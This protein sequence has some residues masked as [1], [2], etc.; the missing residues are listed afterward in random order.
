M[1]KISQLT[2]ISNVSDDDLFVVSQQGT[3][4]NTRADL[5]KSF[6]NG[7]LSGDLSVGTPNPNQYATPYAQKNIAYGIPS[8]VEILPGNEGAGYTDGNFNNEI[9]ACAHDAL[10]YQPPTG[11]LAST[12]H[13]A[14]DYLA[15][16]LEVKL[17]IS[18]GSLSAVRI[19]QPGQLYRIGDIL[20]VTNLRGQTSP[21]SPGTEIIK[22]SG[23]VP[24]RIRVVDIEPFMNPGGGSPA[25]SN[26]GSCNG[27]IQTDPRFGDPL[28][29]LENFDSNKGL[30]P[31]NPTNYPVNLSEGEF[32]VMEADWASTIFKVWDN[33]TTTVEQPDTAYGWNEPTGI[34]GANWAGLSTS[35]VSQAYPPCP[36]QAGTGVDWLIAEIPGTWL[37]GGAGLTIQGGVNT[38]PDFPSFNYTGSFEYFTSAGNRQTS[39]GTY[40]SV[41]PGSRYVFNEWNKLSGAVHGGIPLKGAQPK[42]HYYLSGSYSGYAT[43]GLESGFNLMKSISMTKDDIFT[44][45]RN[46]VEGGVN[47]GGV[48]KKGIWQP[49]LEKFP[50]T[51]DSHGKGFAHDS[52]KNI[53][54]PGY[55]AWSYRVYHQVGFFLFDVK[56]MMPEVSA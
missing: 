36:R 5:I 40:S 18:G 26:F 44:E 53:N 7:G 47:V 1:T 37:L 21:S 43:S 34:P 32:P 6:V 25:H 14:S 8:A 55:T 30:N 39:D 12:K 52:K 31:L 51:T 11:E 22:G 46:V 23:F 2:S 10:V 24:A 50:G 48:V 56:D 17:T 41:L 13:D 16:G 42:Y 27:W 20:E 4:Y 38:W 19:T 3:T 15:R 49:R 54:C 28:N 33:N 45:V 35:C 29:N 9:V